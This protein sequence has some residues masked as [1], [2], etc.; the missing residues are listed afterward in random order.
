M[1][2]Y[3]NMEG[4]ALTAQGHQLLVL[5]LILDAK[6]TSLEA[7]AGSFEQQALLKQQ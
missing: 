5:G 6:R 3:P 7:R 2:V 4:I 1:T